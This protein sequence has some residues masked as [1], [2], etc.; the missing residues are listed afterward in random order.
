MHWDAVNRARGQQPDAPV[1]SAPTGMDVDASAEGPSLQD[2]QT[3]R[4]L[5]ATM[6]EATVSL[7]GQ[8][9]AEANP[10][11]IHY[12]TQLEAID[13]SIS[14]ANQAPPKTLKS[15][16]LSAKLQSEL[17]Q[18]KAAANEVATWESKVVV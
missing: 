8:T 11:Y 12:R 4:A 16:E 3:K 13:I 6:L 18:Q 15:A 17:K 7:E 9:A 2:L 10:Q 14:Q 1:D 5:I